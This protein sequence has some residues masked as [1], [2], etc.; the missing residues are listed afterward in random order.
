MIHGP[1]YMPTETA[2]TY[3]WAHTYI[4]SPTPLL[5]LEQHILKHPIPEVNPVIRENEDR[6]QKVLFI[7]NNTTKKYNLEIS[8]H[9]SK[10]MASERIYPI[11]SE[12]NIN[13]YHN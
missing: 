8:D 4:T 6:L 3:E 13:Q 5:L 10:V 1:D 7:L 12:K 9:K 2:F 11:R